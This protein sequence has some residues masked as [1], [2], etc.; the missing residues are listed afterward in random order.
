MSTCSCQGSC[1]NGCTGDSKYTGTGSGSSNG[2]TAGSYNETVNT[3]GC[4]CAYDCHG[5]CSNS[6]VGRADNNAA[7]GQNGSCWCGHN[8]AGCGGCSGK[9]SG[10]SGDCSGCS[11]ACGGS[12]SGSCSKGCSY[13]CS[14]DCKGYCKGTCNDGC[15]GSC[16]TACSGGCS[17]LCNVTCISDVAYEAYQH[18]SKYTNKSIQNKTYD[19]HLLED[20]IVLDWLDAEDMRH[21]FGMIQE[22]G[23]RRVLQKTGTYTREDSE[24]P[25]TTAQ[26][27]TMSEE[28]LIGIRDEKGLIIIPNNNAFKGELVDDEKH[29]KKLISMLSDNTGKSISLSV[30]GTA[31]AQ[32]K[33]IQKITAANLIKKAIECYKD[34]IKVNTTSEEG[35]RDSIEDEEE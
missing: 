17:H 11:G 20:G 1:A 14:G 13:T 22:E 9:C 15:L 34:E 10:C 32:D 23:R 26:T 8:C 19:Q 2:G 21:L 6:N 12:C 31:I 33:K 7:G 3:P 28:Q 25:K 24:N 29:I 5:G 4:S 16:E 27:L 35:G 18:L 30:G